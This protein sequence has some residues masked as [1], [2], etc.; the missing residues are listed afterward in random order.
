MYQNDYEHVRNKLKNV[1]GLKDIDF[2]FPPKL[3]EPKLGRILDILFR[4]PQVS[5]EQERS[6][7]LGIF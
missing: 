4:V 3:D 2:V 5:Q 7:F 1:Y 6:K